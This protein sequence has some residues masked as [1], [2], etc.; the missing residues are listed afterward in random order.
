MFNDGTNV[1]KLISSFLSFNKKYGFEEKPKGNLLSPLFEGE[2]NLSAGH[3]Y[4]LPVITTNAVYAPPE[5]IA[6]IEPCFRRID[7]G[8]VGY[9]PGHLLLFEMGVFGTMGYPGSPDFS[10][11][12][13]MRIFLNWFEEI[14]L[15]KSELLF[16]VSKGARILDI[17]FPADEET[18]KVLIKL[19]LVSAN[20]IKTKGRRNFIYSKGENRPAGYSIE[21]FY[22]RSGN[23]I[24]VGSVNIYT[25]LYKKGRLV[26]TNN[27]ALG[28]GVGFERLCFVVNNLNSVF[29]IPMYSPFTSFI[30]GCYFKETEFEMILPRVYLIAELIKSLCFLIA[31]GQRCNR[32]RRGRIMKSLVNKLFSEVDYLDINREEVIGNG[33]VTFAEYYEKRYRGLNWDPGFLNN[34]ILLG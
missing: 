28:G 18:F 1:E 11:I 29:E 21:I 3:Q 19:G 20:I 13:M 32:T 33:V 14:G 31:E 17:D 7:L 9:S 22:P 2:F 8:K 34:T 12:E 23:Y 16:T 25:H 30:R 4:V 10:F 15:R 27:Q 5:K 26:Q 6:V 24:E